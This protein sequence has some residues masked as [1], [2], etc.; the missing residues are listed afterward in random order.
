MLS[1]S[2]DNFKLAVSITR[3]VEVEKKVKK[4]HEQ[5]AK[6]VSS[7]CLSRSMTTLE[8]WDQ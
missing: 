7:Q 5:Q 6:D 1:T 3:L 2:E 8:L 4:V